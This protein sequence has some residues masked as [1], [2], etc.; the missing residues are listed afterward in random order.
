MISDIYD[1]LIIATP[2][3][4]DHEQTIKFNGFDDP[5]LFEFPGEYQ[6]TIATFVSGKVNYS[7]F[8][9]EDEI[10]GIMSCDPNKT[11]I[12][13]IGKLFNVQGKKDENSK[14]WKIFSR[15][16]LDD[17]NKMFSSVSRLNYDYIFISNNNNT[18]L[19]SYR[20]TMSKK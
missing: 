15:R 13:S 1:I 14:I 9:L 17:V 6:T 18:F 19:S 20:S 2:M 11:L 3:T 12:N 4:K 7:Y 16:E 10:E 5:D 8:G